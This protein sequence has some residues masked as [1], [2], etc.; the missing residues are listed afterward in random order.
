MSYNLSDQL[1]D[2]VNDATDMEKENQTS[3]ELLEQF[4]DALSARDPDHALQ[5][6]EEW[7][8]KI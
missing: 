4:T 7:Y 3:K 5:I 1:Q 8:R 2:L 6:I